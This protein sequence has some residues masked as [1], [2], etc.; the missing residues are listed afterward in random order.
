MA[1]Y[2]SK[3]RLSL[4]HGGGADDA[5]GGAGAAIDVAAESARMAREY[6]RGLCWVMRYYY[7]GCCSWGWFFPYHYAPFAADIAEA[8][9]PST[10]FEPEL[11]QPF[12]PFEQLMGVLPPRSSKALPACNLPRTRTRTGTQTGTRTLQKIPTDSK[13]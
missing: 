11:G 6:V 13:N 8:I 3:L 5:T 4:A 1:Y 10:P 7:E 12:L 2:R 9:D